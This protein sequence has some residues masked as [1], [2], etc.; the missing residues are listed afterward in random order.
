MLGNFEK[1]RALLEK[2]LDFALKIKDLRSLAVLELQ[3]GWARNFRG[4]GKNAKAHLQNC[5]KYCEQGFIY[6][7]GITWVNLGWSYFLLGD[8]K[9]AREYTEKG[10]KFHSGAENQTD[11]GFFYWLLS[12]IDLDS[13]ELEN[14]QNRAE[15]ALKLCQKMHQKWIEGLVWILLGRISGIGGKPKTKKGEESILQ[16]IKILDELKL[17]ALY[18]PG[19]HYLG[20]LYADTGQKDKALEALK[21]AEKMFQKMGM[22]YWLTKT[23]EVLER[24]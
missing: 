7:F 23:K 3:S 9:S 1:G 12:M 22:D 6:L 16:G 11:M 2:G 13:G 10:L 5:I 8:L 18:A 20:E 24:L 19:Y 21:K 15:K 4:E 14:A 17:K